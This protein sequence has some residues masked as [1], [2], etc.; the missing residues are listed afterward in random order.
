M[1]DIIERFVRRLKRI[2]IDVKLSLN[3]PW[4][5]LDEVN[6]HR[7]TEHFHA[8]HGFTA[9]WWPV[10]LGQDIVFTDRRKVFAKVR[11]MAH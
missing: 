2:G 3:T 6:G 9:F 5:Y 4:V 1:T 11:E 7:V 8:E 10:R